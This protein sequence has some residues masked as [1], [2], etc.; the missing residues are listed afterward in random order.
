M[1]IVAV[2]KKF[3]VLLTV[4]LIFFTIENSLS[5]SKLE[6]SAGYI[7]PLNSENIFAHIKDG[8]QG[9]VAVTLP[10]S[11]TVDLTG[12]II[13]QSRNFDTKSFSFII[14]AVVGYSIPVI[15][16]GDN[17]KSYGVSLGVRLFSSR[18]QFINTFISTEAGIIHHSD[19]YYELDN[20]TRIK[21]ANS[22]TL[23]EYSFGLGLS[24]GVNE[25]YSVNIDGKMS[26][27]PSEGLVHFPVSL[28]FMIP[29]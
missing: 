19:S 26:H 12:R 5:Q 6:F 21:Y 2:M 28:G 24:F 9:S 22:K 23:F 7:H 13:Y 15:T 4:C 10:V 11:E 18:Y 3:F 27:I 25:N 17:L 20:F 29:F 1:I 14:P 16:K 8:F